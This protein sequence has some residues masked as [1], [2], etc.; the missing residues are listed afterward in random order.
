VI[1][2]CWIVLAASSGL[3]KERARLLWR[4]GTDDCFSRCQLQDGEQM[5]CTK[6]DD[7]IHER[8]LKHATTI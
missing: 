6:R 4:F 5:P 7:V 1:E 2:C 8:P 3:L